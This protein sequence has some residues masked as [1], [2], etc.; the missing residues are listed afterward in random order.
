MTAKVYPSLQVVSG[1]FSTAQGL[2]SAAYV[3][4]GSTITE[5]NLTLMQQLALVAE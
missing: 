1:R 4:S 3:R 5:D 2:Q